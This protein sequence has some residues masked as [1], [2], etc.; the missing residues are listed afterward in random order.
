MVDFNH[1]WTRMKT[2]LCDTAGAD[3]RELNSR[4]F[5][6][7]VSG[8]DLHRFERPSAFLS[9]TT[10]RVFSSGVPTVMRIHSGNW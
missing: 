6:E 10:Q 2:N 3:L 1:E 9:A 7:W 5:V 4:P 8:G